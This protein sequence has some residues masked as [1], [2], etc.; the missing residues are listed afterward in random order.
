M[1]TSLKNDLCEGSPS[2]VFV[3]PRDTGRPRCTPEV[4]TPRVQERWESSL[5]ITSHLE[6]SNIPVEYEGGRSLHIFHIKIYLKRDEDSVAIFLVEVLDIL[7]PE[8]SQ[9]IGRLVQ[10]DAAPPPQSPVQPRA[11]PSQTSTRFLLLS[12]YINIFGPHSWALIAY[13]KPATSLYI[14]TFWSPIVT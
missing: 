5:V 2:L 14:K 6:I 10:I 7:S 4:E 1:R 8:L 9:S 11:L 3:E 13:L 12:A